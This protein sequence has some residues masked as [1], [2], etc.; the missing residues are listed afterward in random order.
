MSENMAGKNNHSNK[1]FNN[2]YERWAE[3][4][5]A[6][7]ITGNIMVDRSAL[8][9]RNNVVFEKGTVD[10]NLPAWTAAGTKK[11]DPSVAAAEPSWKT[12]P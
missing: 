7:L 12:I 8:G 5:A 3:G 9:E 4:G 10:T 1:R 11:W 6:L 2:L